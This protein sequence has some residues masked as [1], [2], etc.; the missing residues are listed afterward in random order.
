[1]KKEQMIGFF[2]IALVAGIMFAGC[3]EEETP[4]TYPTPA[5]TAEEAPSIMP[6]ETLEQTQATEEILPSST[7]T[8]YKSVIQYRNQTAYKAEYIFELLFGEHTTINFLN[9]YVP[10]PTEWE[11]QRD[12]E[13]IL[14]SPDGD[15]SSKNIYGK[16]INFNKDNLKN[17]M[18]S[19]KQIFKFNTYE[20]ITNTKVDNVQNYNTSSVIYSEY[21]KHENK[22]ERDFFVDKIQE[23]VGDEENPIKRARKIYDYVIGSVRYKS[24]G[25]VL[26]GAKY[27]YENKEGE[28]G[29]YSALFVAMCRAEGIPAR[30]VVGF[31][32]DSAYGNEHVWAEFYVQDIGWIPVDPTIGQQSEEER[33]YYFGN[34]DNK[35][36]IMSK[37]YN[38]PFDA[39]TA[40]LFHIGA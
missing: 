22:I 5:Q 30:P 6:L 27:C 8:Q 15:I 38:V 34:M 10:I 2:L 39:G 4:A 3:V 13:L 18:L 40:D 33:E 25:G 11:S 7:P 36:L 31:W 26:R 1:M 24:Q 20:T 16:Y 9:V 19:T 28:C 17:N 12:V 21:T 37:G 29:D 32:A 35:R 14:L 23:I